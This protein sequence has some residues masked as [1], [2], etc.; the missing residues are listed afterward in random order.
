MTE[1]INNDIKLPYIGVSIICLYG[2]VSVSSLAYG[3]LGR[4]VDLIGF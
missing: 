3:L 2:I 4:P 1:Y